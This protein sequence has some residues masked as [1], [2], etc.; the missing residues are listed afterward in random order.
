M[1]RF[2]GLVFAALV[3]EQR[4]ADMPLQLDIRMAARLEAANS[5]VDAIDGRGHIDADACR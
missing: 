2:L 3:G 5:A 4:W 1:R